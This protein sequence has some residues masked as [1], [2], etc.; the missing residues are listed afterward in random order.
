[1]GNYASQ[2]TEGKVQLTL[3]KYNRPLLDNTVKMFY[4]EM[5][6]SI[7]TLIYLHHVILSYPRNVLNHPKT[8][9]AIDTHNM[10]IPIV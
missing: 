9:T 1:M 4:R 10:I 8:S 6:Y 5:F 3:G 7:K 2:R